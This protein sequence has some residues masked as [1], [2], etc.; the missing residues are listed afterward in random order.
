MTKK[1]RR[2]DGSNSQAIINW[3]LAPEG[4]GTPWGWWCQH[5]PMSLSRCWS[6]WWYKSTS[7]TNLSPLWRFQPKRRFS[8]ATAESDIT[9]TTTPSFLKEKPFSKESATTDCNILKSCFCLRD[10]CITMWACKNIW[11]I[12]L[13]W[14]KIIFNWIISILLSSTSP[15]KK[16]SGNLLWLLTSTWKWSICPCS[17][18]NSW[19]KTGPR[20]FFQT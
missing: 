9:W 13:S 5:W 2:Q 7:T 14:I 20:I 17:W 1:S 12:K 16:D 15:W 8:R 11:I 3:R 18:W 19:L 6:P 10:P 4:K